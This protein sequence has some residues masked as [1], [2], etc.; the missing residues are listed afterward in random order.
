MRG[1]RPGAAQSRNFSHAGFTRDCRTVVGC[2]FACGC[3]VPRTERHLSILA[4]RDKS[5]QIN[6]VI[7]SRNLEGT[8]HCDAKRS[9]EC[10]GDPYASL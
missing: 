4:E 2:W 1:K 6:Q 7:S 9:A 3:K 10:M 8:W 5:K